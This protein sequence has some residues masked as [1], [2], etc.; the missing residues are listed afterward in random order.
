MASKEGA[1]K[2]VGIFDMQLCLPITPL[3]V[4]VTGPGSC[5]SPQLVSLSLSVQV[6]LDAS[7]PPPVG[8]CVGT[9]RLVGPVLTLSRAAVGS[10]LWGPI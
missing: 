8:R 6:T 1:R 7:P 9:G 10:R 4:V 3:D 2:K 5:E